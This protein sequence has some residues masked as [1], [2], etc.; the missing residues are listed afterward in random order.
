MER[1]EDD[2]IRI[3]ELKR[4]LNESINDDQSDSSD[5]EDTPTISDYNSSLY[6]ESYDRLRRKEMIEEA[7]NDY[8]RRVFTPTRLSLESERYARA[9]LEK[10]LRAIFSDIDRDSK[11]Q[12]TFRQFSEACRRLG[13]V[14]QDGNRKMDQK[15][16]TNIWTLL[17]P[18]DSGFVNFATFC[19]V[20]R[21]LVWREPDMLA[22]EDEHSQWVG[23]LAD[24]PILKGLKRLFWNKLLYTP[25]H[26]VRSSTQATTPDDA[27]SFAPKINDLSIVLAN[28]SKRRYLEQLRAQRLPEPTHRFEILYHKA[29][30]FKAKKD[31]AR[32]RKE[33]AMLKECTFQPEITDEAKR[34]TSTYNRI[35]GP[36]PANHASPGTSRTFESRLSPNSK[37]TPNNS[38]N[39]RR[40]D[41]LE[42]RPM[43]SFEEQELQH[44]TFKPE[45]HPPPKERRYS[46]HTPKGFYGSVQRIRTALVA[47]EELERVRD[48]L[49]VPHSSNATGQAA[50]PSFLERQALSRP[51]PLLYMNIRLGGGKKGKLAIRENDNPIVLA[52]SFAKV[53]GL[54]EGVV[55]QLAE[56]IRNHMEH[57]GIAF[58]DLEQGNNEYGDIPEEGYIPEEEGYR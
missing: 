16:C 10:E 39:L 25:T 52:R 44:C 21:R 11:N 46:Q 34:M 33:D 36:P 49:G 8:E 47:K 14:S 17:D 18:E 24:S 40:R 53:Y 5:W 2:S 42:E 13:L 6:R 29:K 54:D 41:G 31:A 51:K 30:E 38:I 22:V 50:P 43:T 23:D 58:P 35:F 20:M 28:Q 27:P 15:I 48:N 45:I 37:I 9:W 57:L 55:M 56:S 12:F 32:K 3:E 19:R 26:H 7:H 4:I 1:Y